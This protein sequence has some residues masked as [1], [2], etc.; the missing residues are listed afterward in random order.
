MRGIYW[1]NANFMKKL[2]KIKK[3]LQKLRNYIIIIKD[4]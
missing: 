2:K 3:Y 4:S 1:N